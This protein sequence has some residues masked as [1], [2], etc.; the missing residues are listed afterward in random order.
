VLDDHDVRRNP[1]P[2]RI[3]ALAE[4][5]RFDLEAAGIQEGNDLR[6]CRGTSD[7]EKDSRPTHWPA[8]KLTLAGQ[9]CETING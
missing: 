6:E 4:G 3:S 1:K 7:K 9:G 8:P 5:L 2:Q